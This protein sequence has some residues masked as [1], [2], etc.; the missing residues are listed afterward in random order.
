MTLD[1]RL[2]DE[3][4]YLSLNERLLVS[5]RLHPWRAIAPFARATFTALVGLWI[6]ASF[7]VIGSVVIILA[8]VHWLR[9]RRVFGD[10]SFW[11]ATA[12]VVGVLF[13][14]GFLGNVGGLVFVLMLFAIGVGVYQLIDFYYTQIFLTNKRIFRVSG[15]VTRQVA[16]L[17]L[18]ALTDIRYEQTVLGRILNYGHFFVESAGQEQALSSLHFIAQPGRFYRIVM[19]EALGEPA[20]PRDYE[21]P[22]TGFEPE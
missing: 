5:A 14:T 21:Q 15:L 1:W 10:L 8:I 7:D 19:A 12:I 22:P 2:P 4:T 20:A 16:T 18:K 3:S 9:G 6:W 13:V 17:P 11:F